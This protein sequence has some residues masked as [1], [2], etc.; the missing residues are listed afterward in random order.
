M[1]KNIVAITFGGNVA[2]AGLIAVAPNGRNLVLAKTSISF[3]D[4][5]GEQKKLF[6][7]LLANLN[8]ATN[9]NYDKII[10]G[11]PA[12]KTAITVISAS[13]KSEKP[14]K[15]TQ[16]DKLNLLKTVKPD[17]DALKTQT[18]LGKFPLCWQVDNGA[19]TG[20]PEGSVASKLEV[21]ASVTTAKTEFLSGIMEAFVG[22]TRVPIEFAAAS[23]FEMQYL[24]D[25][26]TRDNGCAVI[27]NG[28]NATSLAQVMC[29]GII[30]LETVEMGLK[31]VIDDI[32]VVMNTNDA[33]AKSLAKEALLSI[34]VA[35]NDN[36]IAGGTKFPCKIINDV[37][38]ARLEVICEKLA[39]IAADVFDDEHKIFIAGGQIDAIYGAKN[40]LAKTLNIKLETLRDPLT[41][42]LKYAETSFH[43]LVKAI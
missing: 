37:I 31:D 42:D 41:N 1:G 5:A 38:T 15:I 18:I 27:L 11:V 36:Y 32:K 20:N 9:L 29:D 21:V 43:A 7:E 35:S 26:Q 2:V 33:A 25:K 10:V 12:S 6:G 13:L 4:F 16:K 17:A 23:V 39:P 30:S 40:F 14:R 28:Y 24:I 19:P 34:K 8:S 3:N 22:L